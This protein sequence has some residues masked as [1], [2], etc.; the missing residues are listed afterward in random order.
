[1]A[2]SCSLPHP[3]ICRSTVKCQST[4]KRRILWSSATLE[5][6]PSCALP[7]PVMICRPWNANRLRNVVSS[8]TPDP[9][10][11]RST[12]KWCRSLDL[13]HPFICRILRFLDWL[14]NTNQPRNAKSPE[15][16]HPLIWRFRAWSVTEDGAFQRMERS[17][18]RYRGWSVSKDGAFLGW[19]AITVDLQIRG[20]GI[21]NNS[22][23]MQNTATSRI[24]QADN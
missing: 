15:T 11:C 13:P 18:E 3:L 10:I 4:E 16:S 19:L 12:V 22:R 24:K 7:H 8:E 1:M 5:M 6:T 17:M 9:L 23:G 21:K 14:W 2:P 20:C